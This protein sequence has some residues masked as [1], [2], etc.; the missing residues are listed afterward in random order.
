MSSTRSDPA[1]SPEPATEAS[2]AARVFGLSTAPQVQLFVVRAAL[3]LEI[4][5]HLDSSPKTAGQLGE[6]LGCPPATLYRLLRALTLAG[7]VEEHPNQSF[8]LTPLGEH[9]RRDAPDSYRDF[10][11]FVTDP[12]RF[13]VLGRLSESVRRGKPAFELTFGMQDFDYFGQHPELAALF[14]RGMTSVTA[15][16]ARAIAETYPFAGSLKVTDVGGG[17]GQL[18]AEVLRRHPKVRAVLYDLPYAQE[19][20]RRHLASLGLL[21]RCEL[22][23]G[24]FFDSVPP[25]ADLYLLKHI[26][27]DWP[28]DKA[29][30]ILKN[31]RRALG[32]E[33]RVLIVDRILPDGLAPSPA[34]LADI[35]MIA[36]PGGRERKQA[37]VELLLTAAE[38]Q[39]TR[40]I[41]LPG[42]VAVIEAAPA[43]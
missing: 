35:N 21:E 43:S 25:G 3:Q 22:V 28:D 5:D 10:V 11:L 23:A 7:V 17:E 37:E 30:T 1:A 31:V 34:F 38:L 40:V 39:L 4:P 41:P 13:E 29:V 6:T 12:Y 33:G 36:F 27:H 2:V 8:V 24:S 32:P 9:F 15:R 26:L 14:Q 20:A 18:L 42:P 19:G 16:T